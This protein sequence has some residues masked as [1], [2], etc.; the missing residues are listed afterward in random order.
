MNNELHPVWQQ[1]EL[2]IN[3]GINLVPVR[4]RDET[5]GDKLYTKKSPYKEWRK[6][7]HER[8]DRQTL[9]HEMERYNTTAV[10][11]VCGAISGNLEAIDV[12]V[13]YLP[14]IDARLF[15]DLKQ[16]YPDL[17]HKL[18]V[19]KSPSGGCHIIYRLAP[20]CTVPGSMH[21]AERHATPQELELNPKRDRRCFIE[22]RGEGSLISAPPSAGYTVRKDCPIP[23]LNWEER[24]TLIEI[25]RSYNTYIKPEKPYKPNKA[26][27]EYYDENPFEHYNRAVDPVELL[28]QNGWTFV[29]ERSGYLLFTKPGGRKGDVHASFNKNERFYFVFSTDTGFDSDRAYLPASILAYYQ[30]NN[31]K[32]KTYAWLVQQG[33]GRIKPHIEQTIAKRAAITGNELPTNLS[34]AGK[35]AH[36]QAVE[37]LTSAHPYGVFWEL[38]KDDN[39]TI[40]RERLYTVAHALGFRYNLQTKEPV[41]LVDC[42]IHTQEQ[43]QF[44]DAVKNY[45]HEDDGD[46]LE[47]IHNAYEAFIERH[48]DFTIRRLQHLDHTVILT[49]TR[50]TCYK[51]Y[52]NGY[53]IITANSIQLCDYANLIPGSVWAQKV[54]QRVYDTHDGDCLYVDFLNNACNLQ[55]VRQHVMRTIG[56]LAHEYKDETTAYFVVLSEQCPDPMQGGG[57]GKNLWCN[58][59]KLTTTYTSVPG[60]QKKCDEKFLQTWR[61]QKVFAISDAPKDFNF[62]FLKELTSGDAILKRLFKDESIVGVNDLPKFIIQTNYASDIQDGGVKG[63]IIQIE[64]TGY[65]NRQRGVD[66]HYGKHFP[67]DWTAEDYAGYDTFICQC[68]Q[69]WLQGGLKL[70]NIEL[71]TTGWEKQ[72]IVT[73]GQTVWDFINENWDTNWKNKFVS[74]AVFN[75]QLDDF[76]RENNIAQ[77]YKPTS[78]KINRALVEWCNKNKFG[79]EKDVQKRDGFV[80]EKGREFKE[81]APF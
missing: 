64:F 2:L 33:Y 40:S 66:V 25:C 11:M 39:V 23:V 34:D 43:W 67:M 79:F 56:Y 58:L 26:E 45:I 24:C 70:Q 78:N 9:F 13:K 42:F 10:A 15:A 31:D 55:Q 80:N 76:M 14:G 47:D 60:A 7:Q 62:A 38:D 50:T 77:K 49:D 63:R 61:G 44:Y 73:Y 16:L 65:F 22:T 75:Q 54:Q 3:D 6:Y 59:L 20:G 53:V 4:D 69:L 72:F 36:A 12:D 21:L 35:Q 27:V 51:F 1:V 52:Q 57:S 8:V 41:L 48:G 30:F 46:L 32:Q 37:Q 71:S 28:Q 5:V 18:R 81:D 29:Y 19:H 68:V 17:L 74:N